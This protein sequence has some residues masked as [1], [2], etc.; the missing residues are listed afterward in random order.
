MK[1]KKGK[2]KKQTAGLSK[3]NLNRAIAEKTGLSKKRVTEVFAALENVL[4]EQMHE[5]GPGEFTLPG[6]AKFTV[7]TRPAVKAR[8][9]INPF[10]GEETVFAARPESR[11]VKIRAL[12]KLKGF[13][14]S[15]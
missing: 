9:G 14:N 8:K 12:K 7:V 10:T 5:G 6:L 15:Q 3:G 2:K 11:S 4:A 13:A 1:I